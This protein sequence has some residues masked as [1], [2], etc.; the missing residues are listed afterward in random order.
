MA[1]PTVK[2]KAS[3]FLQ[4][5]QKKGIS[6]MD[7]VNGRSGFN[8]D[9]FGLFEGCHAC[10]SI[11]YKTR[12]GRPNKS[13]KLVVNTAAIDGV[14]CRKCKGIGIVSRCSKSP[15]LPAYRGKLGIVGG[16]IGG[17]ALAVA[18]SSRSFP[19]GCSGSAIR[20]HQHHLR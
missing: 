11:G 15:F 19:S 18:C 4:E 12:R 2:R 3:L 1:E 10:C 6:A 5:E 9:F 17:I 14:V 16:G 20:V 13:Q 7:G 8:G